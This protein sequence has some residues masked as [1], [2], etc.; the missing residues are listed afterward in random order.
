[1]FIKWYFRNQLNLNVVQKAVWDS[2]L[3]LVFHYRFQSSGFVNTGFLSLKN[4]YCKTSTSSL[5]IARAALHVHAGNGTIQTKISGWDYRRR[6]IRFYRG[7][8]HEY[9]SKKCFVSKSF[10]MSVDSWLNDSSL[11]PK[12]FYA[13]LLTWTVIWET[14]YL[15]QPL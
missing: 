5:W 6:P 2:I 7:L 10:G 14:N 9:R 3:E 4:C 11:W 1:M 8:F 12:H 13:A 15:S